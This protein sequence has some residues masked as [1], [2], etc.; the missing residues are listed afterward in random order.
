MSNRVLVLGTFDILHFGHVLY[1]EACTEW[2]DVIIG[3][4]T[5]A[6]T[7]AK[8]HPIM[9]YEE[10]AAAL[11]LL[12]YVKTIIPKDDLSA[13]PIIE[14]VKPHVMTYGS[15]WGKFGW[16]VENKINLVYLDD[17][18]ISLREIYNPEV[19]ST[20]EIIERCKHG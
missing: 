20:T 12:S 13:K 10:R 19:M 8:R 6:N 3:L 16:L 5:D 2:G 14:K 1:L 7:L 4:S 11:Y 9:T 17:Q 15:D 18:G